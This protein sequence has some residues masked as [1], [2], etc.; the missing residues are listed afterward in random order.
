M[1]AATFVGG[2]GSVATNGGSTSH[3]GFGAGCSGAWCGSGLIDHAEEA[4]RW[5]KPLVID[6]P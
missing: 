6:H 5:G 4:A 2:Q 1:L 3:D